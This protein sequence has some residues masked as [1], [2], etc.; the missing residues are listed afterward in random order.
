MGMR[1]TILVPLISKGQVTGTMSLRSQQVGAYKAKEKQILKRLANQIAPAIQN[2]STGRGPSSLGEQGI[3]WHQVGP[4]WAFFWRRSLVK[5]ILTQPTEGAG[6]EVAM[7]RLH[8]KILQELARLETKMER[9]EAITEIL[10]LLE[11]VVD[12]KLLTEQG[13]S[14]EIRGV[15]PFEGHILWSQ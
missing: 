4:S 14:P 3:S 9:E 8:I 11:E 10:D 15:N 5:L 12:G 1:F 13:A 7:Q 2:G 6:L